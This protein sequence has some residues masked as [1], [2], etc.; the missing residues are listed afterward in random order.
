MGKGIESDDIEVTRNAFLVC[1]NS[2]SYV[3]LDLSSGLFF[4]MSGNPQQCCQQCYSMPNCVAFTYYT[5]APNFCW[6]WSAISIRNNK[7]ITLVLI[8]RK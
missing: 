1:V 2:T 7:P 8:H 3:G 5:Q 4:N 6:F